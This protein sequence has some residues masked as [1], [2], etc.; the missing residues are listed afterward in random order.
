LTCY[1]CRRGRSAAANRFA[2][3]F[4]RT[5][6]QRDVPEHHSREDGGELLLPTPAGSGDPDYGVFCRSGTVS[7]LS[8][9]SS[10][11]GLLVRTRA[12]LLSS[13]ATAGLITN[14]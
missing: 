14:R 11:A 1:T 5:D 8:A 12:A 3:T 13:S 10:T 4:N 9:P 7:A 2:C 6:P